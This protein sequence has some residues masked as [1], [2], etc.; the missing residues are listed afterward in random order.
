M[1]YVGHHVHQHLISGRAGPADVYPEHLVNAL[2]TCLDIRLKADATV[3]T[4]ELCACEEDEWDDDEA[5][6][7]YAT[8]DAAIC[9]A[10]TGEG[11][12]HRHK[13]NGLELV[14]DQEYLTIERTMLYI[15]M[16]KYISQRLVQ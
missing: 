14:V 8:G 1:G 11:A 2:L 6:A 15:G 4:A 5:S 9:D 13:L 3:S 7:L 10:I 16:P 12:P